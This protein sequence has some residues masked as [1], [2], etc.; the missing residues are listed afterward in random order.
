MKL[1]ALVCSLFISLI[2]FAQRIEYPTAK[3]ITGD[4]IIYSYPSTDDSKWMEVSTTETWDHAGFTNYDGYAW[5]RFHV[6]IQPSL[7]EKSLWKDSIRIF[8]A[9][10]DDACEVYLNGVKI[11]KSG[12]FPDDKEGYITTWDKRQEFHIA[13]NFPYLNWGGENILSVRVY[14]GGGPGGIYGG[15]PYVSMLDLIDGI[16]IDNSPAVQ[17]LSPGKG[18]KNILLV[19]SFAQK[20]SG[21]LHYTIIDLDNDKSDEHSI[22]VTVMPNGKFNFSF[23]I[24]LA[25]RN[26]IFYEFEESNTHKRIPLTEIIPYILTPVPAA[27]PKINGAKAFGVRPNSPFLFKIPATG[28]KPLQYSINNLPEGLHVDAA[29]GII[30]GMLKSVGEY[31]LKLAVK[32]TLG[33]DTRDFTVKC[34]DLLALTPP[35]GWNSWNCWGLSVSDEKLRAS[36]KAMMD[37]GLIDHGWT[38]MNID[39]G[40]EAEKRNDKGDI[41]ANKKFPDMKKLGDWLHGNGLKFGIYSSPGPTT[42]GNFLGS[43]EHEQQ[44]AKTYADWGIDY[45]KYDWCSYDGIH[46]KMDSSLGSYQKPYQVMQHALQQQHRD[47]LYSLCQYG[48]KEVWKWGAEVNGNCWRTTGDIQDTWESL[49]GIGFRQ[50][51]Q[52]S[53]ARPGRWNDPDMMILGQLGWGD[54][55]HATRLTPDEQYTHV[56]LWSLL[57]APLLIGCDISKLDNFTLSLL[58][59]DEVIAIDQDPLGKQAQQVIKTETY[60]VWV[61]DLEDGSK[62]LGIFNLSAKDQVVRFYWNNLGLMNNYYVRDLWRQKDIGTYYSMFSTKLAPHGVTLIKIKPKL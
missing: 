45:L 2:S 60:Q 31:L 53:Y 43:Y 19:N 5:Y 14:D 41:A 33:S 38:Y 54:H 24:A 59:N 62:A 34:G 61:K 6:I 30:S 22:P 13:A 18:K 55:L 42:C 25:E 57:S 9:K 21:T 27:T 35:M 3:F 1:S 44:D 52:Y 12:S 16:E 11:G 46:N 36:A 51:E 8:L 48:M 47:I 20:I 4:N 37:K 40:W 39:D 56:S 49:S 7:K 58:T 10:V 15:T 17:F 28:K 26:N 32:N 23:P 29:T 50:T